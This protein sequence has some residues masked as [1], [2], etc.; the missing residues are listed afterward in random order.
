MIFEVYDACLELRSYTEF[1]DFI[2]NFN[3]KNLSMYFIYEK[4]IN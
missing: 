2:N 4:L 3:K 1:R